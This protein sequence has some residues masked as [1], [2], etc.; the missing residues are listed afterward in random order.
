MKTTQDRIEKRFYAF[1]AGTLAIGRLE[2]LDDI[3]LVARYE[4]F[5]ITC[6][7][8]L[9]LLKNPQNWPDNRFGSWG[10]ISLDEL[11]EDQ[12]AAV[13]AW[14]EFL[15][16]VPNASLDSE[17]IKSALQAYVCGIASGIAAAMIGR[18]TTAYLPA[19]GK[20]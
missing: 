11:D 17:S 4:D 3:H 20:N 9:V 19:L 10:E 14:V 6:E 7:S 13:L 5:A 2:D 15:M 1:D 16:G 12:M 18:Q 8:K